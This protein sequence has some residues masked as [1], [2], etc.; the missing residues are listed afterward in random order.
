MAILSCV[1]A[2]MFSQPGFA[3]PTAGGVYQQSKTPAAMR[4]VQRLA[5]ALLTCYPV[6]SAS[7]ASPHRLELRLLFGTQLAFYVAGIGM[8]AVWEVRRRDFHVMMLH[9]FITVILIACTYSQ[10]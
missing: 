10:K 9:H 2:C 4:C 6:L 5:A 8:L 3:N 7:C 1:R